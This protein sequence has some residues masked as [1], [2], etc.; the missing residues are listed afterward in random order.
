MNSGYGSC[1]R[2]AP[3]VA[4]GGVAVLQGL[5]RLTLSGVDFGVGGGPGL[6]SSD[7]FSLGAIAARSGESRLAHRTLE[8]EGS[9]H[10]EVFPR[11]EGAWEITR[12]N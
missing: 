12:G 9:R 11:G 5:G 2:T 8:M 7:T 10:Q 4:E 6:I 1:A 3:A